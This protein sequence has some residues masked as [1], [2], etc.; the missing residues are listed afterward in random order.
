MKRIACAFSVTQEF[1]DKIDVR[2]QSLG[3]SRSAYMVQVL[4]N[5]LLTDSSSFKVAMERG[6]TYGK[7][8]ATGRKRS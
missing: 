6:A 5:D 2:A 8:K 3:M 4:R 7:K 1:L